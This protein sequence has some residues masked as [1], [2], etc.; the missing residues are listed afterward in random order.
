VT[1]RAAPLLAGLLVCLLI[2]PR[3]AP[4]QGLP[5]YAPINPVAESRTPLGFEPFRPP[6]PGRWSVGLTLD[7]ASAIEHAQ[8][9]RAS[10]DLDAEILRL[11]V[12][13]ARD[14]S[15]AAFVEMDA[16]VGGSYPGF[17]DGF[18]HWYHNLLGITLAERD[19]RPRDAFL[20]RIVLPDGLAVVR[21]P[22]DLFLGDL[23]VGAGLRHGR[24]LQTVASLTL[25]TSTAP[26]GYG[27][28]VVAA[29]LV[30]TVRVPLAEPLLYEGSFGLGYTP[31]HGD[32][33]NFQRTGFVS[34]TSGLRWR[35]WG[36]QSLYANLF[37][38]SPYYHGTTLPPLDRR[39]L[40]LD[41]GWIL[42]TRSGR[43]WRL[44]LTEDPEPGGPA[45]DLVFRLG[46]TR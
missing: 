11:R 8:E 18:L 34:G 19:R 28:G 12:R 13:L 43:E 25:P 40:S 24:H 37:V 4:A 41:F 31:R 38:H 22:S 16:G 14:L 1:H 10:F 46:V 36:R 15:P 7:Y 35:F 30:T 23:R 2:P 26:A 33:A 42:A 6:R 17:L 5:A 44:G 29:A 20:Y 9:P 32:L 39:E 45:I 3:P 27:R 21:R